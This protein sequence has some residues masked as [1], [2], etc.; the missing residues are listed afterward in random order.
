MTPLCYAGQRPRTLAEEA[1]EA[2]QR[3]LWRQQ[4]AEQANKKVRRNASARVVHNVDDNWYVVVVRHWLNSYG[5]LYRTVR[6]GVD[7]LNF[8]MYHQA[9]VYDVGSIA[10]ELGNHALIYGTGIVR[11]TADH[12]DDCCPN[13]KRLAPWGC[14]MCDMREEEQKLRLSVP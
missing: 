6:D 9:V 1:A 13:C 11:L 3:N 8:D 5:R 2:Q 7:P 12:D 10:K 14:L 4:Q